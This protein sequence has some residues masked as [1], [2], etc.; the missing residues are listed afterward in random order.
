MAIIKH[1][2]KRKKFEERRKALNLASGITNKP[3]V[4][5]A[6]KEIEIPKPVKALADILKPKEVVA[7]K[8]PAVKKE[9][10]EPVK[11]VAAEKVE[12]PKKAPARKKASPASGSTTPAKEAAPKKAATRKK[13]PESTEGG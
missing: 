5:A 4:K 3:A 2:H 6:K 1:R 12:K 13:K 8:K 7:V 11:A 10:P 9:K